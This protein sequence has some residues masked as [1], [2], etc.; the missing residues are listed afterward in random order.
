M[1][2]ASTAALLGTSEGEPARSFG[3][4]Q[5]EPANFTSYDFARDDIEGGS[6]ELTQAAPEATFYVT[7]TANDLGPDG[8]LTTNGAAVNVHGTVTPSEL[9]P[10]AAAPR[11]TVTS[12]TPD[13]PG[14]NSTIETVSD[15]TLNEALIFAGNCA[16]PKD[17]DCRAHFALKLQRSDDGAA[18]GKV[19]IH[20]TFDVASRGQLP[21]Q[22]SSTIAAQ[23]P[24]WTV[25]VTPP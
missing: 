6:V 1:I 11:V 16:V 12:T 9:M 22:T 23:D 4:S 3:A 19:S 24:P 25:Q 14:T 2:I 15:I 5:S 21:A 20:W 8:V 13:A 7:L 18:G 10:G 17:G